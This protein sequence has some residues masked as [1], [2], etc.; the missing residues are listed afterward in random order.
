MSLLPPPPNAANPDARVWKDWFNRLQSILSAEGV[1]WDLVDKTGSSLADLATRNHSS[2]QSI[3]G[4]GQYHLSQTERDTYL[5]G[6]T[7][8]ILVGGGAATVP[9]WTTATGTGKP[10]RENTPTLI[11]P[12]IGVATGTSLAVTGKL[13]SSGTAGVG[14]A[15]GAGGAVTQATN[16][17]TGVTLDKTCGEITMHNANL[18]AGTIVSF[19]LTNS[20]I[21]ATDLLVLNHV[22]TGTRGAYTLN[23]QCGAGS[24]VIY[25]RNNTAGILGEAIV[26]R[27]AV[28]KGVTS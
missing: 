10:V 4:N 8:Q 5:A 9:V 3:S 25:V 15:T 18:G 2:L 1:A 11:T 21:A 6:L 14:Y 22:T 23:A 13:S 19:T 7:T 28:I 17:S 16:K 12:V 20:T 26:I 24:A 27:F